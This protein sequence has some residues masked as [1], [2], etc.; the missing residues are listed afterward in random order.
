MSVGSRQFSRALYLFSYL[1][2]GIIDQIRFRDVNSFHQRV[3]NW[4]T[5]DYVSVKS[6]IQSISG[7]IEI[8][9]ED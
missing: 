8:Y 4:W 1:V 6:P 2:S 7:R 9:Q 3:G 5:R